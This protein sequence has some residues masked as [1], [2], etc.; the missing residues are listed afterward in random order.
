MPYTALGGGSIEVYAYQLNAVTGDSF[1][2]DG[3][4]L[5]VVP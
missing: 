3:V 4:T 5:R 1:D 2:L